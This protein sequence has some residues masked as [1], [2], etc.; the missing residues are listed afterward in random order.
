LGKAHEHDE[1]CGG[2]GGCE[3]ECDVGSIESGDVNGEGCEGIWG[4]VSRGVINAG[5]AGVEDVTVG[6]DVTVDAGQVDRVAEWAFFGLLTSPDVPGCA[7]VGG[8]C[9][10]PEAGESGE[11]GS[12]GLL[13]G[14]I[15]VGGRDSSADVVA[16]SIVAVGVGA[17]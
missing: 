7:L 15:G 1:S 4:D 3:C 5:V 14:G 12:H 9:L 10:R 17:D 6:P 2:R 16:A 8:E 13:T 11:Y